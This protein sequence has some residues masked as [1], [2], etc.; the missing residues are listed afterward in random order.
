[1]FFLSA[2]PTVMLVLFVAGCVSCLT[3]VDALGC[4]STLASAGRSAAVHMV[5]TGGDGVGT[6]TC[7]HKDGVRIVG[8]THVYH[9]RRPS[10]PKLTNVG[11][12]E[13]S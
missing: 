7:G 11:V 9:C 8:T 1:M 4:V 6:T 12:I 3:L 5:L 13:A 10:H 2:F